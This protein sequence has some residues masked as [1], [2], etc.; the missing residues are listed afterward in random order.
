MRRGAR[1]EENAKVNRSERVRERE[2]ERGEGGERE[3]LEKE[4]REGIKD[5]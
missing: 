5:E 3:N 1:Y 2:K 4:N